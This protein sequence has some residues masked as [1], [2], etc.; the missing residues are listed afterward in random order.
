MKVNA[1]K[2]V[3]SKPPLKDRR[4]K[5]KNKPKIEKLINIKNLKY[6]IKLK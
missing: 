5:P 4:A 2:Q 6:M 1:S 3:N